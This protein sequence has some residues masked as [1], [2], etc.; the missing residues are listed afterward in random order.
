MSEHKFTSLYKFW[1]NH[2]I[3]DLFSFIYHVLIQ[4]NI[5]SMS[6]LALVL[7]LTV[8]SWQRFKDSWGS[9][10][11]TWSVSLYI[12]PFCK[13]VSMTLCWMR[14][15]RNTKPSTLK[16][17]QHNVWRTL[18]TRLSTDVQLTLSCSEAAQ[19]STWP[20]CVGCSELNKVNFI[21]NSRCWAPSWHCGDHVLEIWVFAFSETW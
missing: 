5:L 13:D 15:I 14:A 19:P 12:F 2:A 20:H 3:S 9:P 8:Y 16:T 21:N 17:T 7:A 4:D 1:S 18:Q 11:Y 6:Q 10:G